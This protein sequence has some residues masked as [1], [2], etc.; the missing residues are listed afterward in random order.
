M[1]DQD[2]IDRYQELFDLGGVTTS[3]M[4]W[5]FQGVGSGWL[6]IMERL[7]IRL[8]SIAKPTFKLISVKE[9][10][11]SLRITFCGGSDAI[12]EAVDAAKAEA[13]V[14]CDQCGAAGALLVTDELWAVR[15]GKCA[16]V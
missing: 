9:K 2:I 8:Q 14:T 16:V 6:P 4:R 3:Q 5:G 12:G 11:G 13:M 1:T 15:C 10:L 7:C